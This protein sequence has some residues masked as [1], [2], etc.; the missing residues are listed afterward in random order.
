MLIGILQC[1]HFVERE[2]VPFRDYTQLYADMLDGYGFKFR[3]WDVVDMEFPSSIRDAD[4]WLVSGSKH[5]T[6]DDLPFVPR[7]EDFIRDVYAESVPLVGVCF[8]HQIMAQAF[9][10]KAGKFDGGWAI[11]PT[12]YDFGDAALALNAWHQDQVITPPPEA[13]TIASSRFCKHAALAYKG[14]AYSVQPH[15]EFDKLELETLLDLRAPGLVPDEIIETARARL[16][17]PNDNKAMADR[18]AAFLKG[19]NNV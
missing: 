19:E 14:R 17:R 18:I 2:G 13:T 5:G 1:G 10:G 4:G 12:S 16:S 8:G 3:G 9:G 11:G 15:P 7:L 6:Y